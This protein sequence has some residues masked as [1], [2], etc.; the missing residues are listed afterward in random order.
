VRRLIISIVLFFVV[1]AL[2]GLVA[3]GWVFSNS[4]LQVQ[5][6]GLQPEFEI[7]DV[8]PTT[9][10]LPEP[11]NDNQFANTRREGVYNLRWGDANVLTATTNMASEMTLNYGRLGKIL[12]GEG[13]RVVRELSVIAG[14]PPEVGDGARLEAFVF[15][16]NPKDDHDIDYET[17]TLKG[18]A[19]N[20]QAWWVDR[21]ADT[22]VLMVHGRRRG[23]IQETLRAMPTIVNE[24]FSVLALAYRNHG[25]SA[26]SP[27]GFY[28]YGDSEWRDALVALKFLGEKGVK[29]IILYGFSMGAEVVLETFHNHTHTLPI[30]A[31]ILDAPFL[32]PRTVFRN[33]ARKMN[34]PLPDLLTTWAMFVAR[35]RSG[36]NWQTLDQR[37][38]ASQINVPVL[39]F[40]GTADSTIPIELVDDFASKV[41]TVE[42][43]R[44]EGVEHVESWNH[45]PALYEAQLQAFLRKIKEHLD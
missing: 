35:L 32:D 31:I 34:L 11:P 41:P 20:L 17:V 25:D 1:L 2:V 18:E 30:K 36:V 44:N 28:H 13:G 12:S 14:K 40:A 38:N 19:G 10:T 5:P 16:R 6:Y 9:V 22:A 43:H 39:L 45:D 7:L 33:S 8:T 29:N 15:L 23:T 27:D 26:L 21:Q 42:Y 3:V 4:I 37:S 24:G